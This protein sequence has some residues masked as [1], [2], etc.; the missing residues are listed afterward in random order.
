MEPDQAIY[1]V[2]SG[3][4][5]D[6]RDPEP[7]RTVRLRA[8]HEPRLDGMTLA[9]AGVAA[10]LW[11]PEVLLPD[12]EAVFGHLRA[13]P[14]PTEVRILAR[15][16]DNCATLEVPGQADLLCPPEE[17]LTVVKATLIEEI[18][19]CGPYEVAFHAAALQGRRGMVLLV[20]SPGAGKSTLGIALA[21]GGLAIAADD[22]VLLHADGFAS[23]LPFP[24]AAKESS[25]RLLQGLWPDLHWSPEHLRPDGRRAR[26]VSTGEA[27]VSGPQPVAGIILLDRREVGDPDLQ[28]IDPVEALAALI[29]EGASHDERLSEAGFAALIGMLSQAHCARLTYSG[30]IAA[31]DLLVA[32]FA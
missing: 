24:F 17:L 2:E 30:L 27:F 3:S 5:P 15:Y 22:V 29:A 1:E 25:W 4:S 31:A 21:R 26:H 28:V 13:E 8:R 14:G 7:S 6:W 19:R 18:L 12:A 20:G 23:G 10:Q 32:K 9:V 16:A 11:V